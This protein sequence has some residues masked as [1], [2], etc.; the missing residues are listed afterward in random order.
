MSPQTVTGASMSI[1][2]FSAFSRAAPSCM[3]R[4]AADS[5]SRPSDTKYFFSSS[6]L[7]WPLRP[8]NTSATVSLCLGG[9]LTSAEEGREEV[10]G[11]MG[12][13]WG[14]STHYLR[15]YQWLRFSIVAL[16]SVCQTVVAALAAAGLW[17]IV[18]VVY[19]KTFLL[20]LLAIL[21]GP[22]LGVV[23]TRAHSLTNQLKPNSRTRGVMHSSLSSPASC[24]SL[25]IFKH[26]G[27]PV[28]GHFLSTRGRNHK[29]A[30]TT[31][32]IVHSVTTNDTPMQVR[33]RKKIFSLCDAVPGQWTWA[34]VAQGNAASRFRG[35]AWLISLSGPSPDV[36][37]SNFY[38]IFVSFV[39]LLCFCFFALTTGWCWGGRGRGKIDTNVECG[40]KAKRTK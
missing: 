30:R 32:K 26:F 4:R 5:S 40:R 25:V 3:M 39:V 22:K 34:F 9:N 19:S 18:P 36:Q 37:N 33:R 29:L 20:V 13:Q 27:V 14:R 21:C 10:R 38:A 2:V 24:C 15:L 28:D 6:R 17:M 7:G 23:G 8:T 11:A 1:I 12:G 31:R 16:D 35:M